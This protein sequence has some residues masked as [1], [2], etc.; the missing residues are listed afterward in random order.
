MITKNF[1]KI[2][3]FSVSD[4]V[5]YNLTLHEKENKKIYQ[6]K[7]YLKRMKKPIVFDLVDVEDAKTVLAMHNGF[8]SSI[9][10]IYHNG[11]SDEIETNYKN[12]I[13]LL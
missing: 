3:K 4:V 1:D 8:I 7:I 2:T 9:Y 6:F 5:K 12:I 13:E 10:V 11:T